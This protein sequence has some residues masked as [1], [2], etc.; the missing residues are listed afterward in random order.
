MI[1]SLSPRFATL[2]KALSHPMRLE[3]LNKLYI[4]PLNV[5][6]LSRELDK[7]QS[8][9]SQHLQVLRKNNLVSSKSMGK[10]RIYEL[11]GKNIALVRYLKKYKI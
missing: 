9:V 1:K 5:N 3:I 10:K 4:N 2:F 11:D 6:D 7:R 8:N